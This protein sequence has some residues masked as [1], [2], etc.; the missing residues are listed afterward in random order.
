MPTSRRRARRRRRAGSANAK[1]MVSAT[2]ARL[3]LRH[4]ELLFERFRAPGSVR[5]FAPLALLQRRSRLVRRPR[6]ERLHGAL[7]REHGRDAADGG[8][9]VARRVLVV[10]ASAF[11]SLPL[12]E[13]ARG[14]AARERAR[15]AA[16]LAAVGQP[17]E[18]RAV[19][20]REHV[21]AVAQV[22][23]RAECVFREPV[24]GV[25]DAGQV[26]RPARAPAHQVLADLVV[27]PAPVF[28]VLRRALRGRGRG[29]G[30]ARRGD[31]RAFAATPR[32]RASCECRTD[33]VGARPAR[34]AAGRRRRRAARAGDGERHPRRRRV[35][36]A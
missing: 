2:S 22:L 7:V 18:E 28:G 10:G 23:R 5:R 11:E 32:A 16:V 3:A 25:G 33:A 34:E 13:R 1:P 17:V 6:P 29:R 19:P 21:D 4:D 35:L 24:Q 15:G 14:A 9:V 31:A 27:V 36:E 8:G 26:V 30:R 12:L 20:A